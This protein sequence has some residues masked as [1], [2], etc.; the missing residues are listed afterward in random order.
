MAQKEKELLEIISGE[1]CSILGDK[2]VGIYVHGSIAFGCFHWEKSDID[3]LVVVKEALVPAE[4]E[5]LIEVLMDMENECPPKGFEMSVV[6]EKN[7]TSFV[8]P[9]PFELHFSKAH[10]ESCRKNMKEYCSTMHGTDKDLAAHITVIRKTGFALCGRAITEVF[11]KVPREDYLD[12]IKCDI[13][14]A[15]HEIMDNPVYIILNLC[16]VLAYS[17]E[18]L[19][20]SKEQ[21]ALWGLENLPVCYEPVVRAAQRAYGSG[22]TFFADGRLMKDFSRYMKDRIFA[23]ERL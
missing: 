11:D 18:S 22:E 16:R 3:F 10:I 15:E 21:G 17:E 23:K 5:K 4:K 8:Y 13:E 7:C 20:L 12:S 9:T 1:Y 14:N 6:L 2:L 19:V